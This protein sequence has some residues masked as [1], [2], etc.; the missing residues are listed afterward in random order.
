MRKLRQGMDA[1]CKTARLVCSVLRL[2]QNR[3]SVDLSRDIRHRRDIC[4]SQALTSLVS[5]LMVKFWANEP[6][7]QH[8]Q[9]Y[10]LVAGHQQF[11]PTVEWDENVR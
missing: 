7:K 10:L 5:A 1:L 2:Q 6:G 11:H 3:Q 8:L 4:F 9:P